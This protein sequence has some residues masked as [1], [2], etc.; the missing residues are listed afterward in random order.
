[1]TVWHHLDSVMVQISRPDNWIPLVVNTTDA[2]LA[3]A[4]EVTA[5]ESVTVAWSRPHGLGLLQAGSASITLTVGDDQLAWITWDAIV[6]V[7]IPIGS[8]SN[9]DIALVYGWVTGWTRDRLPG[10]LWR[11]KLT[12]EDVVARAAAAVAGDTPW[13][14][15]AANTRIMHINQASPVGGLV[16]IGPYPSGYASAA[17]RDVDSRSVLDLIE[18]T[19]A[20][21]WTTTYTNRGGLVAIVPMPGTAIAW[22]RLVYGVQ[23]A[24]SA[25]PSGPAPVALDASQV[26]DVPRALSRSSMV[27]R[28]AWTHTHGYV[29]DGQS[30]TVYE[31]TTETWHGD[32]DRSASSIAL[33]GGDITYMDPDTMAAFCGRVIAENATPAESL[34]GDITLVNLTAAQMDGLFDTN[35]RGTVTMFII[36]APDDVDPIQRVIGG[37]VTIERGRLKAAVRLQPARLSGLRPARFTDAP[38][39]TAGD[40]ARL[41]WM[42]AV[43]LADLTLTST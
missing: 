3:R 22:P 2:E 33:P 10:G 13:P 18:R 26:E 9:P 42:G 30:A 32:L 25:A 4:G 11:V 17:A 28:V 23:V 15:E 41:T 19:C 21:T 39:T 29:P 27:N 43:T 1:M 8:G 34:D 40:L 12:V 16:Q 38:D 5:V 35:S 6:D 7:S 24:A 37:A 14:L 31:D 20:P 36:D